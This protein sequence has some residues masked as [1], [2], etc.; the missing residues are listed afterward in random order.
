MDSKTVTVATSTTAIVT[1]EIVGGAQKPTVVVMKAPAANAADVLVGGPETADQLFP[2]APGESL[3][4]A[5]TFGEGLY[6]H[7]A[8]STEDLHVLWND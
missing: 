4:Y 7:V 8:A 3:T 1:T 5:F 2:I 6:G